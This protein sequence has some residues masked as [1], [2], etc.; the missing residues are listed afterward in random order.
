MNIIK[1]PNEPT[2]AFQEVCKLLPACTYAELLL[3]GDAMTE[4]RNK[5]DRKNGTFDEV[6]RTGN[7]GPARE[8]ALQNP[9]TVAELLEDNRAA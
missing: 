5:I 6:V 2:A 1:F 4:M 9:A 7:L 3:I 8:A